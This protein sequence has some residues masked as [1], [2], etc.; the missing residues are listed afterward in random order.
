VPGRA[1]AG[2]GAPMAAVGG[3]GPVSS[4]E[5][6]AYCREVLPRVS[7]TFALNMR[8]LGGSMRD[9]VSVAYLLCRTADALEDSWPGTRAEI[10]R[11]FDVLLAA[12]GGDDAA[13]TRLSDDA[14]SLGATA[15]DLELVTRLPAVLRA[16]A[17]LDPED[18]EAIGEAL[19]VM[20][21]GMR[22][23]AGRAAERG[24]ER[25]YL[26][27]EYE[28]HDYC[29][30]VAGCI[31]V[32]L[33]RMFERRA[34]RSGARHAARRLALAPVVGE[35]LQLTNLL[36]DWPVDVRRG[37]C[38]VP[39]EWLAAYRLTPGDLVG[40]HRSS[41]DAIAARL[42]SLARGA[43]ARVP[44]YLATLPLR[45]VRYRQFVLWPT[46]WAVDSLRRARRDRQF[47]WGERRPKLTR[48][49]V[50]NAA[51][52]ALALGHGRSGVRRLFGALRG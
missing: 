8:L 42:E 30:V 15:A 46:V 25:A 51:L 7:R 39:G 29:W 33:T 22:R 16:H 45:H 48:E 27:T 18:R 9:A 20:C 2:T 1:T 31:G 12:I 43:L 49:E 4:V 26:D 11:R 21:A 52:A 40:A 44:D 14:R 3:D 6:L 41:I 37:R 10:E 47:P 19:E 50:R 36:L 34:G 32:M 38:H 23:Y 35:A 13:A 28:L 17:G 24:P 5:D